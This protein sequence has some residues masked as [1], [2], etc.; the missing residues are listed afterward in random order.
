[1]FVFEQKKVCWVNF[2]L[3][4]TIDYNLYSLT[5]FLNY[6]MTPLLLNVMQIL[7]VKEIQ[8]EIILKKEK[9]VIPSLEFPIDFST[10]IP[11][12]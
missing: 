3:Y 2:V 9:Y 7:V 11:C 5:S 10:D 4:F 8:Y 1:M 6:C 12:K